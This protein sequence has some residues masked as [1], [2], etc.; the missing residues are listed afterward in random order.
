MRIEQHVAKAW[1]KQ[2]TSGIIK[3]VIADLRKMKSDEML[4]V[5]TPD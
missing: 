4:L 2:L 5:M 3:K 1:A